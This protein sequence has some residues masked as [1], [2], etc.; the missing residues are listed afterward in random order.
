MRQVHSAAAATAPVG[1]GGR[2]CVRACRL[3]P[4]YRRALTPLRT[5][6]CLP[7]PRPLQ[8]R[9]CEPFPG[10]KEDFFFRVALGVLVCAPNLGLLGELEGREGL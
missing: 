6:T 3:R 7:L 8:L 1:E 2:A 4:A 9:D 5:R 10:R